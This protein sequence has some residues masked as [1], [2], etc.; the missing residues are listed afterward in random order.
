MLLEAILTV[1]II[2]A[3][4]LIWGYTQQSDK[5]TDLFYSLSFAA[6]TG[7]LWFR[8]ADSLIHHL[9]LAMILLWGFRLGSYLFK[10]IHA[11]G[12]DDRFDEMRKQFIRFAGFWTIQ[13]LSVLILSIPIIIIYQKSNI[14]F[15]AIHV[16]GIAVWAL[17]LLLETV[18]DQQKF[19]FRQNPANDGQ[20]IQS[21]LWKQVQHPNYLG[22]ILCWLGVFICV[23]PSLE[24]WEWLAIISP[25]WIVF[26]L[27]FVSG[28]PLLQK[29]SQKKYGHLKSYQTYKKNTALLI[30]FLY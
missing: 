13:A 14:E 25:I 24:N 17:G 27:V 7:V 12:K 19:A 18:A 26:L 15:R 2:N 10:R 8:G 30:P 28:I 22:E 21:G 4:G 23:I 11:I 5:A 29:A 3:I 9:L 16:L 20:F 6:L 1:V